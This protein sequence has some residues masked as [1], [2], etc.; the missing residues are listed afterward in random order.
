VTIHLRCIG[1]CYLQCVSTQLHMWCLLEY[2]GVCT[3]IH[4]YQA[5]C[6]WHA[7]LQGH[8]GDLISDWVSFTFSTSSTAL[9]PRAVMR[10]GSQ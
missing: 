10:P 4:E 1:W 3:S 7:G 8:Y 6:C 5:V 9:R 2:A